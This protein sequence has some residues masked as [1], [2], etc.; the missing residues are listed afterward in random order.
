MIIKVPGHVNEIGQIE[1]D[2]DFLPEG[3]TDRTI[4]IISTKE[5]HE[6]LDGW[7]TLICA[8]QLKEDG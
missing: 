3:W 1:I 7:T 6:P 8:V 2:N 4:E 5:R